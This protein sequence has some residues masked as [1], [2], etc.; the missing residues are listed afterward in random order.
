MTTPIDINSGPGAPP[1][2]NG[3]LAFTQPWQARM[4][5]TV[6]ALCEHD[7]IDYEEFRAILIARIADRDASAP[8]TDVYWD[9]W[10][11]AM[12]HLAIERAWTD[13]GEIA[14]RAIDF[15]GH[16]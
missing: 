5:A 10:H 12:E 3:E 8:D 16:H 14:A 7:V 2:L 1:R 6:M 9:A 4:F 11:D 15:D 13:P